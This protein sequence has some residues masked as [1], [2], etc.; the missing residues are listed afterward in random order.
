[1]EKK[2]HLG[3]G[4]LHIDGYINTDL[5]DF[6]GVDLVLDATS[7]PYPFDDEVLDEIYSSHMLEHI[8]F[9]FVTPMVKEWYR[10]LKPQGRVVTEIPDMV[11]T[12]KRFIEGKDT[13]KWMKTIYGNV[14]ERESQEHLSLIHI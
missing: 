3:S 1:M 11:E 8:R 7:I 4:G 12:C 9:S 2:L 10:I 6:P 13:E 14:E 5:D